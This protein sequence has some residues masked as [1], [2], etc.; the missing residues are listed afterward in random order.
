[1][2]ATVNA[3]RPV[4]VRFLEPVAGGLW[5]VIGAAALDGGI[6]TVVLAAGLGVVGA[7]VAA[8]RRSEIVPLPRGARF[9][10]WRAVVM[11]AALIAVSGSLLGF[12]GG[13]GEL[14]VPLSAAIGGIAAIVLSGQVGERALVGLGGALMVLG[15]VGAVLALQ[16]AGAL[17]PQGVVGMVAAALVW[18]EGAYR[19]GLLREVRSRVSR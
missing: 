16:S 1:M 9:R 4:P 6:G 14:T 12:L 15:A 8:G 5:W 19:T 18:G 13:Y 3:M 17:Y 7:L 11:A 10:F 2:P